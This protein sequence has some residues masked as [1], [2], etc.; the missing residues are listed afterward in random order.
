MMVEHRPVLTFCHARDP[1]PGRAGRWPS[2]STSPSS[3]RRTPLE[4]IAQVPMPL[5]PGAPPDGEL[6]A[7]AHRSAPR[8]RRARPS[9]P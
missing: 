6:P 7:G 3:P 4:E 8:G 9:A 1:H 2:R 5:L